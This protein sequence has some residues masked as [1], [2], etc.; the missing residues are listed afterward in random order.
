M[1]SMAIVI[2]LL[3]FVGYMSYYVA[4]Q[5]EAHLEEIERRLQILERYWER[6]PDRQDAPRQLRR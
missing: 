2:V 5:Q 6:Q 1:I 4:R 3:S